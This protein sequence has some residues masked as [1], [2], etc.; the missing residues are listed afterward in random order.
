VRKIC[1]LKKVFITGINGQ[2]GSY[3][4]EHLLNLNCEVAGLVRRSSVAEN[5]T[6]RINHLNNKIKTYYGDLIDKSSIL[7]ALEDFRPDCI[8]NLAAQS[9]VRLSFEMPSFTTQVNSIGALNVFD[10]VKENFPDTKVYQASSSEMFGS[11]V[12]PDQFQRETTSMTPVSP[13]GCS[14]L[15]SYSIARNYRQA[16]GLFISNGILFNHESPRRGKNFVTAKVV[17]GALDI[18]YGKKRSLELGNLDS[19]RDWG[20]SFDYTKAMIKLLQLD[21][22]DDIVISTGKAHSVRDV[23]EL[24]FKK[25]DLNYQ[26]HVVIN[27]KFFR[28]EELPYLQGDSTKAKRLLSWQPKYTFETLL[29]DMIDSFE[30]DYL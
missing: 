14:K 26:D 7:K 15:Y 9:H 3:L 28:P 22:P 6:Y 23:C 30:K 19:Y 29:E 27:K 12:D 8:F 1:K 10:L 2:D 20:H 13:Y 21:N 11:S 5:Q 17:Q 18:K 25:M 24:V 16:Y 4:A